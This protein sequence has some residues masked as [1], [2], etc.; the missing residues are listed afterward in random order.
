MAQYYI[1]AGEIKTSKPPKSLNLQH[2]VSLDDIICDILECK[3]GMD[4]CNPEG[5]RPSDGDCCVTFSSNQALLDCSKF[6]GLYYI[7]VDGTIYTCVDNTPTPMGQIMINYPSTDVDFNLS[8]DQTFEIERTGANGKTY[9]SANDTPYTQVSLTWF[10][11]ATSSTNAI[12]ANENGN[13]LFSTDGSDTTIISQTPTNIK[14]EGLGDYAD[15]TAAA[16]GG[17]VL[18]GLYHTSGTLKIRLV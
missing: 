11:G 14:L 3:F 6:T 4:C 9:I 17:V 18:G 13:M 15:D 7:G 8:D 10:Y 5:S 16:T 12:S 2:F 1:N